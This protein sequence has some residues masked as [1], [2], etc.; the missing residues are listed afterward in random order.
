MLNSVLYAK[1]KSARFYCKIL[2][3]DFKCDVGIQWCLKKENNSYFLNLEI[4]VVILYFVDS[5]NLNKN[6]TLQTKTVIVLNCYTP[7]KIEFQFYGTLQCLKSSWYSYD[8]NHISLYLLY[9][10]NY[11]FQYL[12]NKKSTIKKH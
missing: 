4:C 5:Y 10:K 3:L 12:F 7:K 8:Q 11:K 2:L 9:R 1:L 6:V